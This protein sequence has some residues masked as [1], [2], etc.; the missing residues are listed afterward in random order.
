MLGYL[1]HCPLGWSS[2]IQP[3]GNRQP[4]TGG[5]GGSTTASARREGDQELGHQRGGLWSCGRQF[6]SDFPAPAP[7]PL[8]H[9]LVRTQRKQIVYVHTYSACE[10]DYRTYV[11]R[12]VCTYHSS[13]AYVRM[14]VSID[15]R[16]VH[17]VVH[18]MQSY[19]T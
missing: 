9:F 11:T 18:C 12:Y 10:Q 15:K 17:R 13:I 6:W 14:S 5:I 19:S 3:T 4:P 16:T 8:G 1:R 2:S 7:F